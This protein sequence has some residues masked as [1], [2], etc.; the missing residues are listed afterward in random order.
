MLE[1]NFFD[2]AARMLAIPIP[3]RKALRYVASGFAGAL[4]S[5]LWPM[6]AT[7]TDFDWPCVNCGLSCNSGVCIGKHVDDPCTVA[8]KP[9]HCATKSKCSSG[10]C[11]TCVT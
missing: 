5:F 4:L 7:A 2:E 1:R 3:R 11:C 8:G 9:G 6:R 10:K